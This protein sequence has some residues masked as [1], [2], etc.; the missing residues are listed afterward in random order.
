VIYIIGPGSQ[1]LGFYDSINSKGSLVAW[2]ISSF[3][4][5]SVCLPLLTVG[6]VP[7][8]QRLNKGVS[9]AQEDLMGQGGL[10]RETEKSLK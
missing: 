6:G 2:G 1:C 8:Q 7:S 3:L 9:G 4:L 10:K 5:L